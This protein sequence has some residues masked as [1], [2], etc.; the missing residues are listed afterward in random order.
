MVTAMKLNLGHLRRSVGSEIN[1]GTF[2][3]AA[4]VSLADWR[5]R[6]PAEIRAV[7]RELCLSERLGVLL[8]ALRI[9]DAT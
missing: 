5:R 7:W 9:R 8:L 4:A 6:V 2:D 1:D 3:D